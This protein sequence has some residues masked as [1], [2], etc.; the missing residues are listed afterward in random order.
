MRS[1]S[2]ILYD[3]LVSVKKLKETIMIKLRK[4]PLLLVLVAG[5]L[6]LSR[7]G[8]N[9]AAEEIPMFKEIPVKRGTFISTVTANGVVVPI[10]RIELKS[11]ASGLIEELHAEVGDHVKKG[12]LICR[13]DQ[14]DELAAVGQAQADY[15]I[16]QAE[17]ANAKQAYERNEQLYAEHLVSDEER[18]QVDLNLAVAKGKL[19]QTKTIL[20]R[21]Q[22]RLSESIVRSPIDGLILQKY[23]EQGQIIASGVSNVSGGTPIVDVADMRNVYIKAGVDEIDIGRIR[24]GQTGTV[25]AEAYPNQTFT[26]EIVRIAPE[27]RIEQNVTLFD[28]VLEVKNPDEKLKS[29][30][31]TTLE[32]TL[33]K[34]QDVLLIP[35]MML[36]P[37]VDKHKWMVRVKEDGGYQLKEV[38]IGLSNFR[39]AEVISGLKEGDIVAVEMQ[40][41]LKEA[42]DELQNRIRSSRGFGNTSR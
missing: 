42:N 37:T 38:E 26:G 20:D 1:I 33:E 35:K 18:D 41:R 2:C 11:K 24:V 6:M 27:A 12:D 19:F 30:M 36:L 7:C 14:K 3:L 23:V 15:D 17:L 29:G 22:E 9:S 28:I 4:I 40:S 31:N 8:S 16:A 39:D 25:V 32:V 10:D 34:K 21:A 5:G 13:L